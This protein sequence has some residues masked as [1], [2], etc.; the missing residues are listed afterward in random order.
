MGVDDATAPTGSGSACRAG[1][2]NEATARPGDGG[3]PGTPMSQ[4]AR[5]A[6]IDR[7]TTTPHRIRS[8][9]GTC[10]EGY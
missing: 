10:T 4:P 3:T 2:R 9:L 8:L 1:S 6:T 7:K 5:N